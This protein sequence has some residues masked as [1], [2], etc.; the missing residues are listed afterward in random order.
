MT[1]QGQ[2]QPASHM[3]SGVAI[4]HIVLFSL[5]AVPALLYDQVRYPMHHVVQGKLGSAV[6]CSAPQDV[7][8]MQP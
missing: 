4:Y 8:L 7:R 5:R 1:P 3:G 2:G 6:K